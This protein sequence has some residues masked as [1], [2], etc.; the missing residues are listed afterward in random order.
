MVVQSNRPGRALLEFFGAAERAG[1]RGRPR[2]GRPQARFRACWPARGLSASQETVWAS[3]S[4]ILR[5]PRRGMAV[6]H[7]SAMAAATSAKPNAWPRGHLGV[8]DDLQQEIASS[9]L[10]ATMSSRRSR[11]RPHRLPRSCT[12]RCLEGLVDVPWA[13]VLAVAQQAMTR[14]DGPGDPWEACRRWDDLASDYRK[15]IL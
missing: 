10:R 3:A 9:S 1:G 2:R 11:R 12:A 4:A 6:D 15:Y 5:S 8:I 7:L 14:G 13:A